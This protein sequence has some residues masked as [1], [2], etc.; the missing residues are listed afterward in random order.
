[1]HSLFWHCPGSNAGPFDP[2]SD[3]LTTT[4][5]PLFN[6]GLGSSLTNVT[7]LCNSNYKC[8]L[9]PITFHFQVLG[10]VCNACTKTVN[11]TVPL[12]V[13]TTKILRYGYA[14]QLECSCITNELESQGA[15][16]RRNQ[17]N[18]TDRQV[19]VV[20]KYIDSH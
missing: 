10:N 16:A 13:V 3:T 1:M 18:V 4:P 2:K 17:I 8:N 6:S 5:P 15:M 14:Q 12:K 9:H 19:H 11:G 7:K 20:Y